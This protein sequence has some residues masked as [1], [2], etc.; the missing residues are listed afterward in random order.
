MND[1]NEVAVNNMIIAL[2]DL[3]SNIKKLGDKIMDQSKPGQIA[4]AKHVGE[5]QTIIQKAVDTVFGPEIDSE[6]AAMNVMKGIIKRVADTGDVSELDQLFEALK[7]K[8]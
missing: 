1:K 4:F 8:M 2:S 5:F 3:N 6:T 7:K